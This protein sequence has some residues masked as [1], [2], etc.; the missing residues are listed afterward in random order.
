MTNT[1]LSFPEVHHFL[2][3][4]DCATLRHF[5]CRIM[6]LGRRAQ[7]RKAESPCRPG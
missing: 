2:I 6:D 3:C 5:L 4:P 1:V 7:K